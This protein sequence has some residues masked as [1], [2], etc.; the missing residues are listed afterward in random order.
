M[1]K[2]LLFALEGKN[3][4]AIQPT[5]GLARHVRT[6]IV[7]GN[8]V[9]CLPSSQLLPLNSSLG[10]RE[11]GDYSVTGKANTSMA[12][13]RKLQATCKRPTHLPRTKDGLL[14][15][16]NCLQ[17][18]PPDPLDFLMRMSPSEMWREERVTNWQLDRAP[19]SRRCDHKHTAEKRREAIPFPFL[20]SATSERVS[21]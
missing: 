6:V 19:Q 12:Q 5:H 8:Y 14:T 15:H 21:E 18:S 2:E 10:S 13:K 11:Q 4:S 17:S 16:E 1:Q 20:V 3:G 9:N 7:S